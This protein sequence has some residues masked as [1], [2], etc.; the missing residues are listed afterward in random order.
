MASHAQR[1]SDGETTGGIPSS[2][3]PLIGCAS[4][5]VTGLAS[6]LSL[7]LAA[8]FLRPGAD[9]AIGTLPMIGGI[10]FAFAS[11]RPPRGVML[12]VVVV[13]GLLADAFLIWFYF[14][15]VI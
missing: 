2:E 10:A 6:L 9:W 12:L 7:I 1:V 5:A 8:I 4:L 15:F 3:F 14:R 13:M 11:L